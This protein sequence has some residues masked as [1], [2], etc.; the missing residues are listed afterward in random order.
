[1]GERIFDLTA[2]GDLAFSRLSIHRDGMKEHSGLEKSRRGTYSCICS[3]FAHAYKI[4][5]LE[6]ATGQQKNPS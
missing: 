1:M 4:E 5:S 3:N 6:Q 2:V